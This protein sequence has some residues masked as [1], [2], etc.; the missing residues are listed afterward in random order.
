MLVGQEGGEVLRRYQE[1]WHP[2]HSDFYF[3]FSYVIFPSSFEGFL[4]QEQLM[5]WK[6]ALS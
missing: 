4:Q 1:S 6:Q 3:I 5:A 2:E